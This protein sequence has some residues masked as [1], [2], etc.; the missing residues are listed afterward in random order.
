MIRPRGG[1]FVYSP[2]EFESMKIDIEICKK[3][4]VD[5]V[6]FGILNPDNTV[7]K[8]RCKEL[9]QLALPLTSNFHRAFDRCSDPYKSL[10]DIIEC[11]FQRILTSGREKI[12]MDSCGRLADLVRKSGDRIIIMPGGGVRK[13]NLKTLA[14]ITRAS[15]FHTS[16]INEL[17]EMLNVVK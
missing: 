11:G 8:E 5:G 17:Q 12:A 10:E 13:E 4:N 3:L 1:D 6:V 14:N 16:A 15:E 2:T 7:D 9:A